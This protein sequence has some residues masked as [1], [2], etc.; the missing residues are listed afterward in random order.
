ML[1]KGIH[2]LLRAG[3]LIGQDMG[4]KQVSGTYSLSSPD[5]GLYKDMET[6]QASKEYSQTDKHKGGES[7][8]I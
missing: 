5:E 8:N 1:A 6:Y 4:R 2:R 7:Y 3:V